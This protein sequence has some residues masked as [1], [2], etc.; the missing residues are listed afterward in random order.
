MCG[1]RGWGHA[2]GASGCGCPSQHLLRGSIC[3]YPLNGG[4]HGRMIT[5]PLHPAP[6]LA[7]RGQGWGRGCDCP[8]QPSVRGYCIACGCS[9]P[10]PVIRLR[11]ASEWARLGPSRGLGAPC[12]GVFWGPR[13]LRAKGSHFW[14]EP[15][16]YAGSVDEAIKGGERLWLPVPAHPSRLDMRISVEWGLPR[17]GDHD[18]HPSPPCS[19]WLAAGRGGW[20]GVVSVSPNPPF[21]DTV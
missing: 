12:L 11:G 17:A 8:S 6:W 21:A 15:P 19:G 14:R 3:E 1:I 4:S 10:D 16:P 13:P 9:P 7:S 5:T 2:K 20:E 18:P